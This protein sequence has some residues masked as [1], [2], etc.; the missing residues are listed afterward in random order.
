MGDKAYK[1]KDI[2][3]L[4]NKIVKII[5]PDKTNSTNKNNKFKEKKLKLRIKVENIINNVKMNERV[6]TRKEK[7]I[8]YYMSWIYISCLINNLKC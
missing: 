2:I 7:N 1:C 8:N 6:K 5:T 3:K 4:N